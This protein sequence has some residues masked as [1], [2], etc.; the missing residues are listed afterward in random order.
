MASLPVDVMVLVG[1]SNAVVASQ[2]YLSENINGIT[3]VNKSLFAL[4]C[5][6]AGID[7]GLGSAGIQPVAY[8]GSDYGKGYSQGTMFAGTSFLPQSYGNTN[9]TWYTFN[10]SNDLTQG[11]TYAYLEV[12]FAQY[13]TYVAVP[14]LTNNGYSVR[15]VALLSMHNESDVSNGNMSTD[16]G[17]SDW[18]Q[19]KFAQRQDVANSFGVSASKVR[20]SFL[21]V[22]FNQ[23]I[24]GGSAQSQQSSNQPG[25][26]SGGFED[27][28]YTSLNW[29]IEMY[30]LHIAEQSLINN[31]NDVMSLAGNFGDA[32]MTGDGGGGYNTQPFNPN[33][34]GSAGSVVNGG[35]HFLLP[36]PLVFPNAKNNDFQ[37]PGPQA[38]FIT[39]LAHHIANVFAGDAQPG[40]P[41]SA[42]GGHMD[43]GP[44]AVSATLVADGTRKNVIVSFTMDNL[45]PSFMQLGSY[46][47]LGTGWTVQSG[48]SYNQDYAVSAKIINNYQIQLGFANPIPSGLPLFYEGIGD[49]NIAFA[50]NYNHIMF[51]SS[52]PGWTKWNGQGAAIYDSQGM[53][54]LVSPIGISING[55]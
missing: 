46:A 53:P 25:W 19:G 28:S 13:M 8:D 6:E 17:I 4:A 26:Q 32:S 48:G 35:Y 39:R 52:N 5:I 50:D 3:Y 40:S 30:R 15:N 7:L 11:V 24:G 22:P 34:S 47:G 36:N 1:Q 10:N 23:P 16:A 14:N 9:P 2:P 38:N 12:L 55:S 18:Q 21:W 42:N 43:V 51:P 44:T 31:P 49:G 41:V 20:M 27:A 33:S 29:G 54:I 37:A 45:A